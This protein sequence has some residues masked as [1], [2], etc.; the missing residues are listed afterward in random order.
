MSFVIYLIDDSPSSYESDLGY[1]T[2]KTYIFE[3]ATYA[4]CETEI[5][6]NTK[7]Y[8]SKKRAENAGE[9]IKIRACNIS[10]WKIKEIQ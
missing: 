9:K 7:K 3:G 6:D 2:G 5:T 1:W 4:I 8:S 10:Q